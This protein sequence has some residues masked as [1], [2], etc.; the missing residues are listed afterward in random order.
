MGRSHCP[1]CGGKVIIR[2][3][4]AK[5]DF[6]DGRGKSP[7]SHPRKFDPIEMYRFYLDGMPKT[8]LM[9]RYGVTRRAINAAIKNL[10]EQRTL[11]IGDKNDDTR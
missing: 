5:S 6:D 1:H 2:H 8:W 10:R 7:L 11:P 4:L 3:T 9:N